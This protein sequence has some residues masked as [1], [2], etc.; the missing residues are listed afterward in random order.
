MI[1]ILSESRSSNMYRAIWNKIIDLVL[2]Q[3]L[4]FIMSDYEIAAMK[5]INE[6][7]PA[8]EAHGCWFHYNQVL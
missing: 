3:N 6:P 7:F 1:F 5:V 4:K 8:V 2:Q